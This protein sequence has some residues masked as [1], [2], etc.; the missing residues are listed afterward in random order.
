MEEHFKKL[1]RYYQL[2]LLICFAFLIFSLPT[3]ETEKYE[4]AINEVEEIQYILSDELSKIP[5][6]LTDSFEYDALN[7][8]N[9]IK[10]NLA[11]SKI[12]I[13]ISNYEHTT[14][15]S[16]EVLKNMNKL[17]DIYRFFRTNE[18]FNEFQS[19]KI[20]FDES[21]SDWMSKSEKRKVEMENAISFKLKSMT[22]SKKSDN[23]G[24]N[25]YIPKSAF[26]TV[27]GD[28]DLYSNKYHP[29]GYITSL[30]GYTIEM[31]VQGHI[32]EYGT[33]MHKLYPRDLLKNTSL[34][35]KVRIE[36]SQHEIL[37]PKL[38]LVWD[39]IKELDLTSA[40]DHLDA[41]IFESQYSNGFSVFG[42]K[43]D[44]KF[45]TIIG[46]LTTLV[47]IL[48]LFMQLRQ[49]RIL[50]KREGMD[51]EKVN[52]VPL[53]SGSLSFLIG[54]SSLVVIPIVCAIFFFYHFKIAS[55]W[56]YVGILFFTFTAVCG[57]L[58]VRLTN[59]IKK[60]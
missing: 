60:L 53:Y 36:N 11:S 57:I 40:I 58:C 6:T 24:G 27:V 12:Q 9:A 5:D 16:K 18:Q 31:D 54:L 4:N 33:L 3:S 42:I 30:A 1:N 28:L 55:I 19:R 44:K 38:R 25:L 21:F 52:W 7:F 32:Q 20:F 23:Q 47:I 46:P 34:I 49:I 15:G 48:F 26:L 14:F 13:D 8:E 37:F 41:R 22:F 56:D 35:E 45:V 39:E 17:E 59:E 43:I 51:F 2:F 50:Q 29:G 10:S